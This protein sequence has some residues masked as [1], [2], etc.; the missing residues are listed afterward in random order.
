MTEAFTARLA[1]RPEV[2]APSAHELWEHHGR[3]VCRFA[4]MVAKNDSE[5]EDIAQEALLRAMRALP[6][7]TAKGGGLDAWLW[8]IV[9]NTARDFG[10]AAR[11]RQVLL[12]RMALMFQPDDQTWPAVD[13]QVETIDLLRAIRT[14]PAHQRVLI[15]LR[16]GADL[17]YA[18][19]GKAVGLSPM[20][21]RAATRR[22]LSVLQRQLKGIG[23][24]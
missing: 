22:A 24:K 6:S 8:R 4:A 14:L 20:A 19:V 23:P 10:R 15:G 18:M 11:R 2:E 21:A 12:E 7:W 13:E 9:Q 16:F 5:A 17:D 1:A 3:A